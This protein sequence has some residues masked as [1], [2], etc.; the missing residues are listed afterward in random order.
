MGRR[1]GTDCSFATFPPYLLFMGCFSFL[2]LFCVPPNLSSLL[3]QEGRSVH[4]FAAKLTQLSLWHDFF[5]LLFFGSGVCRE[6]SSVPTFGTLVSLVVS[7]KILS[8]DLYCSTSVIF[9]LPMLWL[10]LCSSH[11]LLGSVYAGIHIRF[12]VSALSPP[13]S[14]DG[15][16]C[17]SFGGKMLQQRFVLEFSSC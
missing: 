3:T 11:L 8:L 6:S 16:S 1:F 15:R 5:D 7:A 12:L 13:P 14:D 2:E 10:V 9:L 4:A 17:D